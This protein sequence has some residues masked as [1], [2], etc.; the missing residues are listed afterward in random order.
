V[1]GPD[2][3]G[4]RG[5]GSGLVRGLTLRGAIAVNIIDMVGVGPF[6]TLPLIVA[7]MGGPQAMLGWV[8]G[9]GFALCDGLIWAEL[10]ATFPQAGGSYRYLAE[11]YGP[12]WG[13]LA[14]FLFVWQLSFSAPLSLA[15]GCIGLAMYAS[16]FWP[17]LNHV[18]WSAA[19]GVI[20]LSGVTLVAIAACLLALALAYRK[21]AAAGRVAQWLSA[22]VLATLA[23]VILAAALHFHPARAFAFPTRAFAPGEGFFLGLGSAML[24]ATYDYWGYYNVAFLGGEVERPERNIPRAILW[25][26]AIVAALYLA[27]NIGVLG[28]LRWRTLLGA[29]APAHEYVIA[30]FFAHLYG[31][32]A[33]KLAAGLIMAAAFASVFALL[34]GYSRVPYAAARDGNYFRTFAAVH[35][36]GQFPHVAMLW[37]GGVAA[38]FCCFSLGA[39]IAAL[40][41][42]RIALQFLVQAIGLLRLRRTRPELPRP[43][44]MPFY[45]W[46]V[47]LAVAGF[48]YVLFARTGSWL[49]LGGAGVVLAAGLVVYGA[50][51]L[52]QG[53]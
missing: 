20:S 24:I 28:V 49:Q 27:M 39:V 9:A 44:R 15:S 43:F 6:I 1:A 32:W 48:V 33:A 41:V 16:Y 45:P 42:I 21:V 2:R 46:P 12:K 19:G 23:W 53:N 36:R 38:L 10:G 14:A 11:C 34:L 52:A 40:V 22:G 17:G 25:S 30:V 29:H 18:A 26:I 4:E 3:S 51:Q 35:P 31:A 8:L 37:L 50:R 13:R 47:L 7:A 5:A